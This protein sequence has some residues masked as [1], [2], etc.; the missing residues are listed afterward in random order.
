MIFLIN[1]LTHYIIFHKL[2]SV[3]VRNPMLLSLLVCI[4]QQ[5]PEKTKIKKINA[6]TSL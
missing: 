5:S 3:S 2:L 4:L 6:M 1:Q